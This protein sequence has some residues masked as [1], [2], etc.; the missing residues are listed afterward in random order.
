MPSAYGARRF[1][2]RASASASSPASCTICG[3]RVPVTTSQCSGAARPNS[4]AR[5]SASYTGADSRSC[6]VYICLDELYD[7][8]PCRR[9]AH[10]HGSQPEREVRLVHHRRRRVAVPWTLHVT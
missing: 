2:V 5:T 8:R 10:L 6:D 7:L 3:A 9:R 1:A 4:S